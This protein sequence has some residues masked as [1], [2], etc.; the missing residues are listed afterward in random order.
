MTQ[1]TDVHTEPEAWREDIRS[2]LDDFS[3][4]SELAGEE[5]VF[6]D[7][8]IE[9]QPAPHVPPSRLPTGRMAIYGFWF[10]CDWLKIGKAGPKTKQR[11]TYQHYNINSAKST[12][13]KSISKD[14]SLDEHVDGL[15]SGELRDWIKRETSRVNILISST[16]SNQVLSLLEAFLHARIRP[17]YEGKMP[18]SE[19]RHPRVSEAVAGAGCGGD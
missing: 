2:A 5:I 19:P 8:D 17:R 1:P 6:G 9:F 18:R 15:N 7:K 14:P 4:V 3:I 11:Y 10:D 12:L 16:R 13:A